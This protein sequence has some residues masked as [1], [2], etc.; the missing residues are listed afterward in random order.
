MCLVCCR[1]VRTTSQDEKLGRGPLQQPITL[2]TLK[3]IFR[4]INMN[5]VCLSLRVIEEKGSLGNR[6]S[7]NTECNILFS[8]SEHEIFEIQVHLAGC[9]PALSRALM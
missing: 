3:I 5:P 7:A 9:L 2:T 4:Q 8:S 1:S 6:E